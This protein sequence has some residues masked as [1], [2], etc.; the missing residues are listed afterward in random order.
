MV[1]KQNGG[2]LR[3]SKINEMR[4][5]SW[6]RRSKFVLW[7]SK[8]EK[9]L[10]K[11]WICA[12]SMSNVQEAPPKSTC[13]LGRRGSCQWTRTLRRVLMLINNPKLLFLCLELYRRSLSELPWSWWDILVLNKRLSGALPWSYVHGTSATNTYTI[14]LFH[15]Q[16]HLMSEMRYGR[17]CD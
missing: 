2:Q 5:K 8:G 14:L 3:R 11:Y 10:R 7:C 13:Q 17:G 4:G 12:V 9:L 1:T 16:R 6:K 15:N